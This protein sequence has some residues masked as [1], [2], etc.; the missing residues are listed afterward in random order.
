MTADAKSYNLSETAFPMYEL[1]EVFAHVLKARRVVTLMDTCHA[2]GIL[3][4]QPQA[5][6]NEDGNETNNLINQYIEH[7]AGQGERAVI[8]ASDIN[9]KS[10]EGPQWGKGHGVFTYYLLQ[11]LAGE[12]D[13]NH[14]GI[15]TTGELFDYLRKMVSRATNGQQHPRTVAGFASSLILSRSTPGGDHLASR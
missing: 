15:V 7:F 8:T 1:Q 11:G 12:A 13:S 10:L 5:G 14:D 4:V 2:R 6:V 9:E 3:G